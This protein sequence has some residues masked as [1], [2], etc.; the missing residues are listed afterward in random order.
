MKKLKD[1]VFFEN[2]SEF[3]C[4]YLPRIQAK[5]ELTI[6]S[7]KTTLNLLISYLC[8]TYTVDIFEIS[9]CMLT[10]DTIVGFLEWLETDRGNS[11]ATINI[12]LS[13][14]R[15]FFR[16][17]AEH[18]ENYTLI[19]ALQKISDIRR[20]PAPKNEP[21][22][23]LTKSQV[24]IVLGSPRTDTQ[25]G[26]R[27]RMILILLY[28]TG[29]RAEELLSMRLG[30]FS[31]SHT[32]EY[33]TIT[34]KNRKTRNTPISEKAKKALKRYIKQFHP[35]ENPDS[36]L[37]YTKHDSRQH[38]MSSDNLARIMLKYEKQLRVEHPDLPHLHPHIWRHTRAQNLYDAGM[39]L[40]MVS[41]WLGHSR[42]ESTLIYSSIGIE[43]KREALQKATEGEEP[44]FRKQGPSYCNDENL[45][46][47]LYGLR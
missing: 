7:Y 23:F 41:A 34:G 19:P 15:T 22:E 2:I 11:I 29:C 17:L 6:V 32:T 27:D 10:N 3:L 47:H 40:E 30:D 33:V 26:V 4:N 43:R 9:T 37:F 14:I 18:Q 21:H 25:T 45:V 31:V 13:C 28:D 39:P 8:S 20:R 44:L 16:Y 24:K 36:Y 35:Y 46:K 1:K 5:S 42:L 38:K 12:R